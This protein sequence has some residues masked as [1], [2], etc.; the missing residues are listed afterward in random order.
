MFGYGTVA[1]AL[2]NLVS[3]LVGGELRAIRGRLRMNAQ[4]E[5]LRNHVIICGY[6]RMGRLIAADLKRDGTPFVV[7]ESG[8]TKEL[9]T[10]GFLF[11]H[12]DATEDSTLVE[13]GTSA[14]GETS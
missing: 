6:G 12:G 5:Q 9:E 8:T 13:A 4:I 10:L 11:V 14:R 2:A 1:I 7:I 3:L